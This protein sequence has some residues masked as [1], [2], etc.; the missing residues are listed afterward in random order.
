M[1]NGKTIIIIGVGGIGSVLAKEFVEAGAN[2]TISSRTKDRLVALE[3]KLASDRV[4]AVVADAS[5]PEGI[6]S[7]F[8]QTKFAFGQVD[9]VVIAAGT[10]KQ[11]SIDAP[12]AEAT[13]LATS[14]YQALFLPSFV[15]GYY[16]QRF[17]REQGTGLIINISSHAALRP[18]LPGNLT[19]GPMKA[20]S[21]HFM[22]ALRHE[23]EGSKVRVADIAP[24][25]VNTLDAVSLLNTE[26]KRAK[27]V[28]PE[29]IAK[30]IIDNFDNP[31][32]EATKIFDAP[33][34]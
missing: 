7:V 14:H 31:K 32:I 30:W 2:V 22:L 18:E 19:Y 25:I 17:F 10:W 33:V 26:E 4:L 27:A 11:L 13:D 9:A 3:Q 34:V 6:E 28:Q 15:T 21:H 23:L 12:V 29:A 1:I 24:A 5:K 20:A 8:V 16:A